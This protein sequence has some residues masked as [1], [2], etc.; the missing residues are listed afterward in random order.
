[1]KGVANANADRS[2]IVVKDGEGFELRVWNRF[3][4]DAPIGVRLSRKTSLPD[5][6]TKSSSYQSAL[7]LQSRWQ[8]W[9]DENPLSGRKRG[10]K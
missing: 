4:G 5:L 3:M 9:L 8:K 6:P 1:M 10:K 7:D 2:I